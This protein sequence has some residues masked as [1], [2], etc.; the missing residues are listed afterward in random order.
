LDRTAEE[1][2]TAAGLAGSHLTAFLN[3]A[4]HARR[5]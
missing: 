1:R 2:V 4:Q 5:R 3:E